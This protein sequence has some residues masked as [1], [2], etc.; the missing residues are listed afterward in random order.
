M[1]KA[2]TKEFEDKSGSRIDAI[3]QALFKAILAQELMP[4]TKLSEEAIGSLFSVSRTI[5]RAALNRLHTESLV[6]FRQNRGAFVAST[7]PDEARQV[8]EARNAIEREI[9]SKLAT[10][11]TDKQVAA[12]ENHLEKEHAT[13]D[14][15]DHA[16]AILLSG[17]FHLLA[18]HMSGNEVLAG[19]LKSL[20]SR[21]S[22]ILAQH[23]THQESDCSVDEHA[24]VLAALRARDERAAGA[25]IV[26]HL[27]QVF[28]RANIGQ[29]KRTERNLS[30]ILSRY[31]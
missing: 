20:I 28:E 17:E 23:S 27:Q 6:E 22:L 14:A 25:A 2:S 12:L 16:A 30:E 13:S 11:I 26:D 1:A 4:G 24:A 15:H 5:V 19:F 7:T 31:A 8:F 18:A 9:F 10:T 29:T 21:T 3:Y